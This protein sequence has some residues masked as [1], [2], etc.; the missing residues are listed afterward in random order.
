MGF[1]LSRALS[2]AGDAVSEIYGNKIKLDDLETKR[3]AD[4]ARAEVTWQNHDKQNEENLNNR[5]IRAQE[6]KLKEEKRLTEEAAK[7]SAEARDAVRK[8]GI[9]PGTKEGLVAI[10]NHLA[11]ISRE[12]LAQTYLTRGKTLDDTEYTRGRDKVKDKQHDDEL[13]VRRDATRAVREQNQTAKEAAEFNKG[14]EAAYKRGSE[15]GVYEVD[16]EGKR[17]FQPAGSG[18]NMAATIY[19]A[20]EGTPAQRLSKVSSLIPELNDALANPKLQGADPITLLTH[21]IAHDKN[22]N[23]KP[24]GTVDKAQAVDKATTTNPSSTDWY[25]RSTVKPSTSWS[26]PTPKGEGGILPRNSK[27]N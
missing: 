2:G 16:D 7:I 9:D 1:S 17:K 10:G 24:S 18:G 6:Y 12:D 8:Q 3:I 27:L 11:S 25:N 26:P 21:I 15:I 13:N 19:N 23:L 5:N 22:P 14:A 4:E 20:Y